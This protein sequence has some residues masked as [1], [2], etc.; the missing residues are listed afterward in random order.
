VTDFLGIKWGEQAQLPS[1]QNHEILINSQQQIVTN[2]ETVTL[3]MLRHVGAKIGKSLNR[4]PLWHK[5]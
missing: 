2:A 4:Y 5:T 3:E 1:L